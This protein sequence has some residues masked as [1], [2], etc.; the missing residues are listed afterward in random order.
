[1]AR[2]KQEWEGIA[3]NLGIDLSS[4]PPF[5]ETWTVN[6]ISY[7]CAIASMPAHAGWGLKARTRIA[8]PMLCSSTKWAKLSQKKK[9]S[10]FSSDWLHEEK[11]DGAR[12]ILTF[13]PSEGL[14]IWSRFH[15]DETHLPDEWTDKLLLWSNGMLVTPKQVVLN[16]STPFILDG[17]ITFTNPPC[18]MDID[19]GDSNPATFALTFFSA[20][21]CREMI[22]SGNSV[23]L[24]IFD[25]MTDGTVT[26]AKPL[27]ERRLAIPPIL[28]EMG[29]GNMPRSVCGD[30]GE[31]FFQS[32]IEGG[33]EGVVMKELSQPYLFRFQRKG[34]YRRKR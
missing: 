15:S 30:Q 26:P 2:S 4:S 28:E 32:V 10:L 3:A 12:V 24:Y 31:E 20:Q 7:A 19:Y 17:E 14:R 22:A 29:C 11:I 16:R 34:W 9:D 13:H 21:D 8:S 27:S 18:R 33:G 23:W 25:C 6:A 5:G 1:M